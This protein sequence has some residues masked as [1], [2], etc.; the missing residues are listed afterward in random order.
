MFLHENK[1]FIAKPLFTH[2]LVLMCYSIFHQLFTMAM[3]V[4]VTCMTIYQCLTF[5][6]IFQ[7][8][9]LLFSI[10]LFAFFFPCVL[11]YT[12]NNERNNIF[13]CTLLVVN[14]NIIQ[15]N[16]CHL[17]SLKFAL[18]RFTLESIFWAHNKFHVDKL[19]DD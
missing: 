17:Q 1:V 7:H 8:F 10:L 14:A 9:L 11:H 16:W 12:Y 3:I 2:G 18:A 4:I 5:K 15:S 6:G 19:T 13:H